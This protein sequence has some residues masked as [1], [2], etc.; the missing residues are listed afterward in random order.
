MERF[1]GTGSGTRW[2]GGRFGCRF[3]SEPVFNSSARFAVRL[4]SRTAELCRA[5]MDRASRICER[6][7]HHT[8]D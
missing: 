2:G 8:Q 4:G 5:Q 1:G 7:V 3:G 6:W